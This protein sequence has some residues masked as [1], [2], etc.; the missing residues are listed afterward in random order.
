MLCSF[1]AELQKAHRRHDFLLC[2]LVPLIMMILWVGGLAPSD[3]EELANGYS[4]LFYSI[5]VIEAILMPVL[6]A[7]L[8]SRLWEIEVK[9]SMPKLLYTLQERRSLF[10]GKATFGL[11]E[12]LLVTLLEMGAAVLLGIVQGYTEAFPAGQFVYLT[13]CA[14]AVNTML[15]CSEFLLMLWFANPLP[16][17][18]VGI[19]GALVGLFSAFLPPIVSYFVP[20]G[21]YIPL[22]A[23][24]V[25]NW[26]EATRTITYGTRAFNWGLLAF[27]VFLG[28]V[29][30]CAAWRRVQKLEV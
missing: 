22:N 24:E 1:H 15:F 14:L 6:M 10:A 30:F 20:W 9:G 19:V 4:A 12:I 27:T 18:C 16:A 28:A 3:P 7:V 13:V 21:Y 26:D 25:A 11:L 29:L 8:A 17:L 2:L 5:P 23:Y